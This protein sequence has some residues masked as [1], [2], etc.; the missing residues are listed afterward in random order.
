MG[1]SLRVNFAISP[2]HY[3]T[4]RVNLHG[5]KRTGLRYPLLTPSS[6]K[7]NGERFRHFGSA[8]PLVL[9]GP[10]TAALEIGR[11]SW[12]AAHSIMI[13]KM[14]VYREGG[15]IVFDGRRKAA[16]VFHGRSIAIGTSCF[17]S[18]RLSRVQAPVAVRAGVRNP[19]RNQVSI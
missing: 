16:R 10:Q 19:P 1:T 2:E 9:E 4:W 8:H 17:E 13:S 11:W 5:R 14:Q 15:G 18:Q 3:K 7:L 12:S 6:R